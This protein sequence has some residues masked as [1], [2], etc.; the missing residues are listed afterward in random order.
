[1]PV[2]KKKK[3]CNPSHGVVRKKDCVNGGGYEL[4]TGNAN[5]KYSGLLTTKKQNE[6]TSISSDGPQVYL[7]P[8]KDSHVLTVLDSL[9]KDAI[10]TK[11]SKSEAECSRKD[12][13]Q[14]LALFSNKTVPFSSLNT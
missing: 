2:Q 10:V 3:T 6:K 11:T 1:M 8:K 12:P 5:R 13:S 9:G 4:N 7:R 14:H